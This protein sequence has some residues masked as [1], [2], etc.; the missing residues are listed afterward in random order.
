MNRSAKTAIPLVLVLGGLGLLACGESESPDASEAGAEAPQQRIESTETGA[1]DTSEESP[2]P[3]DLDYE[4]IGEDTYQNDRRS[5][6][7]RLNRKVDE[8]VLRTLAH[9]LRSQASRSFERTFVVYYLPGMEV[10]AGGWATSHFDPEL[11]VEVLGVPEDGGTRLQEI[12]AEHGEDLIG[13][14]ERNHPGLSGT[15]AL[16]RTDTGFWLEW[17]YPDGSSRTLKL[18]EMLSGVGRRFEDPENTFGEY[19]LLRQGNL[20]L[21]DPEGVVFVAQPVSGGGS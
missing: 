20:E 8:D 11:D 13:V 9:R 2:L 14:W 18:R 7:V 1:T 6:D 4:I 3:S 19:W 15:F 10:D 21:R 16:F 5:L 17:I 12:R